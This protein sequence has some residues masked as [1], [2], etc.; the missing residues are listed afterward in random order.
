[1]GDLRPMNVLVRILSKL[2][3]NRLKRC[4]SSI[5]TDTPSVFIEVRLLTDNALMAFEINHYMKR[6]TQGNS[7]I[8]GFKIDVSKAYDRLK[9]EF[10]NMLE[11]FGFSQ[12]WINSDVFCVFGEIWL[13]S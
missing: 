3:S 12:R 2:M 11:R 8:A 4:L 10:R 6:K 13:H 1:M 7:G 9:W 5:I